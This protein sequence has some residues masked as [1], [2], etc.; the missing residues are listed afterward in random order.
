MIF[1]QQVENIL[2]IYSLENKNNLPYYN[3]KNKFSKKKFYK[4]FCNQCNNNNNN[5]DRGKKYL[6]GYQK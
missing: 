3:M 5:N 2:K 4:N 1:K 6:Q